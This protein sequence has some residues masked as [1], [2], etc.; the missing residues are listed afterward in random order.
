MVFFFLCGPCVRSF[1]STSITTMLLN[2]AHNAADFSLRRQGWFPFSEWWTKHLLPLPL[3]CSFCR[4][5]KLMGACV[6]IL[7]LQILLD[8][9]AI[10]MNKNAFSTD[11]HMRISRWISAIAL[12][13]QFKARHQKPP[14]LQSA[15][16]NTNL[17]KSDDIASLAIKILQRKGWHTL[18]HLPDACRRWDKSRVHR[19]WAAHCVSALTS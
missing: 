3:Q 17:D 14:F 1:C 12:G 6:K 7:E 18:R 16:P 11:A 5:K 8:L 4:W 15:H 9:F 2:Y 19:T 10:K 13:Q